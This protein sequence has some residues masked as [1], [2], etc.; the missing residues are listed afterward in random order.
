M[1]IGDLVEIRNEVISRYVSAKCGIVIGLKSPHD[2]ITA[3][4][5]PCIGRVDVMGGGRLFRLFADEIK[6][7]SIGSL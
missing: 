7:I 4:K 2:R 6:L 5:R 3:V 1:S